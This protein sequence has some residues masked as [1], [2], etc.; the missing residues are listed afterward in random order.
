M[1]IGGTNTD[2]VLVDTECQTLRTVKVPSTLQ[3]QA[4]GLMDGLAALGASLESVRLITHGTTVAT[5]ATIERTGARCGLLTTRGFRDILELR[6]RDRPR[7]YGLLG[8]FTPLIE[9]RYRLEVTERIDSEGGVVV[10]LDESGVV[11]AATRLRD[12]G[13]EVLVVCFLHSY[14]NSAHEWRARELVSAVWPNRYIVISSEVLPVIREFERTSTTVI[15]G[16]VQPLLDR[17]LRSLCDRLGKDGYR[18]ELLV[19]QSNGGLV[20]APLVGRFAANTILSGPA[21]GVTAAVSVAR[22]AGLEDIV[23]CDMGGTS[24]DVCV[25]K[26]L[27]VSNTQQQLIDFGVPLCVPMVDV[28]AIGAGGG[29][30]AWVDASGILRLGPESAGSEPGPACFGLGGT[31]P[32]IT[33]ANLLLGNF[34]PGKVIGQAAGRRFDRPLARAAIEREIAEPLGLTVEAAAEAILELAGVTMGAFV[35]KKLLERGFD[36]RDFSL[37]AFGGAGPLHANRILRE[38][39]CREAMIPPFPGITSAIGCLL[40][41]LRHD[42]LSAV[43]ADVEALDFDGMK[44]L[45]GRQSEEG[46]ALLASEGV[47]R[48]RMQATHTAAMSYAGQTH[49]IDVLLP[50][51]DRLDADSIRASFEQAYATRYARVLQG[52]GIRI[53][54]VKTSVSGAAPVSDIT[55]FH[56]PPEGAAPDPG[57]HSL[58]ADGS[59]V[60]AAVYLRHALPAGF[61]TKGPALLLQDDATTL[62]QAGYE[63]GVGESG[64]LV[65]RALP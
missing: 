48:D 56:C 25:I 10:P 11:E 42:F 46:A 38:S 30:I 34:G 23:S 17:Y 51:R 62:V 61:R 64:S 26:D 28:N 44:D 53:S 2:L 63:A 1:D 15:A 6:R 41:P 43:N 40:G 32:T 37:V 4:I 35:R 59:V 27:T 8:S 49:T 57:R 16:Y 52:F 5:N 3:N 60:E 39:G 47:A 24:F 58:Y 45:L 12:D 65:I 22:A 55:A 9:R 33:D 31:R 20:S 36:P 13:C 14:A 54:H 18:N 7:T 19:V 21:A 29:S 50:A